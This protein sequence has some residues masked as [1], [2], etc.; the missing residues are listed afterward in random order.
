MADPALFKAGLRRD[1]AAPKYSVQVSASVRRIL[2]PW[3][4]PWDSWGWGGGFGYYGPGPGLFPRMEQPWFQREVSIIVREL[5]ANRVVYETRAANDGPWWDSNS[6]LPAM[7]EAALQGF[8]TAPPGPR[9]VNI[10]VGAR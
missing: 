5:P 8:P 9:R 1:D 3:S 10:Q 2:S 4:D 7:F 6:V